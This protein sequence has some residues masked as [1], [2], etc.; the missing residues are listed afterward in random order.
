MITELL[1]N[2]ALS[3]HKDITIYNKTLE[4]IEGENF[5]LFKRFPV[6][7]HMQKSFPANV[8][9]PTAKLFQ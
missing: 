8:T 9:K 1:Y 3:N 7:I 5:E 6:Y 4:A 2:D